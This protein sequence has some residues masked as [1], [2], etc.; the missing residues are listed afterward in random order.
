MNGKDLQLGQTWDESLPI[1]NAG[2]RKGLLKPDDDTFILLYQLQD[3]LFQLTF[4]R[5][6]LGPYRLSKIE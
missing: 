1:L 5:E 3:G 4:T 2:Q 6:G